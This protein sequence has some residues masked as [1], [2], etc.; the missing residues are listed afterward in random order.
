M[1]ED[2]AL[3]R[4]RQSKPFLSLCTEEEK[5]PAEDKDDSV[6]ERPFSVPKAGFTMN[7]R[8]VFWD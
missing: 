1:P 4:D 6:T 8:I 5:S 2:E 7:I 3:K